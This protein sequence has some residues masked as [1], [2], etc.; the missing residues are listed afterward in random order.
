M[1]RDIYP[2]R[3]IGPF[4]KSRWKNKKHQIKINYILLIAFIVS[5]VTLS[6]LIGDLALHLK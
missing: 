6:Y 5:C 3:I 2:K 1:V 4:F